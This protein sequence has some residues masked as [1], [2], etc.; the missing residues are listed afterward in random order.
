MTD[1]SS[2][3]K[4]HVASGYKTVGMSG[5]EKA[6]VNPSQRSPWEKIGYRPQIQVEIFQRGI[7]H[8][9]NFVEEV[10]KKVLRAVDDALAVDFEKGFILPHAEVFPPR[11]DD[12]GNFHLEI[13]KSFG[14]FLLFPFQLRFQGIYFIL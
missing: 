7:G 2:I 8:E 9:Q 10:D 3:E 4:R 1:Q 12:A 5:M 11:K 6:G 13:G 14:L